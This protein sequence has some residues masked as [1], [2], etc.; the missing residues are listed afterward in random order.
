MPKLIER[1]RAVAFDLDGTLID[2]MPDLTAA[3]NLMLSLLGASELP[4]SRVR[5]LVGDGVEQ[6][7]SRATTAS[8][9]KPPSHSSQRSAALTLFRRLYSKRLCKESR[10]YAGVEQTLRSC[11]DAG[12]ALCCITNKESAFALP[13]LEQAGL[14]RFFE[15]TSSADKLQDRKPSPRML[16]DACSRF[17][18]APADMLYVGDSGVDVLAARAAGCPVVKVTYGYGKDHTSPDTMADGVVDSITELLTM[19]LR[20]G[21]DHPHLTLCPTGAT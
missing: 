2:T 19:D 3:V 20:V 1:C 8:L 9:G 7:V 6:L 11:A 15:F 12:L 14:S 16:L 10:V 21:T 4:A 18:I 13:L 5:A 17:G